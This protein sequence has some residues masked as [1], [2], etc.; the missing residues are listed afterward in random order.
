MDICNK[1]PKSL[2][3]GFKNLY[4]FDLFK[5]TYEYGSDEE[6][7]KPFSQTVIPAEILKVMA[8][9]FLAIKNVASMNY[10]WDQM[11]F[12]HLVRDIQ[13]FH[14]IQMITDD[15]KEL[16]RQDLYDL[17][18]YSFEIA[19]KGRFPESQ[20]EVNL[21]I[22]Q[23]NI[24]TNYSYLYTEDVKICRVH[25]FNKYEVYTLDPQMTD[26]FRTWMQLK[27]RSSILISRVDK[28]NRI[29]FFAKQRKIVDS[30]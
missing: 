9:Y 7:G 29:E 30:M 8:E 19:D 14:S 24:N 11:I 27:K 25:V 21:Y 10:I 13:Y 6:A 17:L 20:R 4:R 18:D 22:S 12:D 28:K 26:K 1:L 16:I 15:E 5:W 3:T 2:I 23:V